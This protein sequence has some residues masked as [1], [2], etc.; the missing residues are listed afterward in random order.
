MLKGMAVAAAAFFLLYFSLQPSLGNHALWMAFIVY[1]ILRGAY[2]AI[3][4]TS[5]CTARQKPEF[6]AP[7]SWIKGNSV[8]GK[9]LLIYPFH[10]SLRQSKNQR[11][12][13]NNQRRGSSGSRR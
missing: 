6:F 9:Q 7:L 8:S 11:F 4:Y 12:K 1:L 13:P 2:K 10:S 3:R 5:G